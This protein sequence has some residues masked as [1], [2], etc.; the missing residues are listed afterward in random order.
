MINVMSALEGIPGMLKRRRTDLGMSL[1]K[2][3]RRAGTSTASLCRYE[4]G[5]ARFELQT[6]RRLAASLGCR[7]EVALV[8]VERPVNE[9]TV[10]GLK[11]LRRLFWDHDLA[12]HDLRDSGRWVVGR[13]VEHG[14]L[15]D[16]QFLAA[17]MGVDR[18]LQLTAEVRFSSKRA[19]RFW[20]SIRTLEG[21]TCMR[22]LSRPAAAEFWRP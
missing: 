3:A 16:I 7:L 10:G 6:L 5:W 14:D 11:R 15:G 22:K 21:T 17:T 12:A 2:V 9:G 19:A 1:A 18:F 4:R 13:V 20:Q 8:P